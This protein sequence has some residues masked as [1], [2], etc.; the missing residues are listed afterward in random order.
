MRK[1][2]QIMKVVCYK[3][4]T[5][6]NGEHPL[7]MRV[8]KNGKAVYR[9]IGISVNA[10]HWDFEKEQPK[11]NCPNKAFILKLILDKEREYNDK[12]IEL[13]S[14]QKDF[15]AKSLFDKVEKKITPMTVSEMF[16]WH[17]KNLN[18]DGRLKYALEFEQL[19]N[20]MLKFKKH[21]DIYFSEID[22]RWLENY[23]R[24]MRREGGLKTNTIGKRMRT[25]RRLYN[26]AIDEH[27]VKRDY[28]PFESYHV[29]KLTEKTDNRALAKEDIIGKIINYEPVTPE[30]YHFTRKRKDLTPYEY[31]LLSKDIFLF[32]YYAAGINFTDIAYLTRNNIIGAKLI[33]NKYFNISNETAKVF[34]KYVRSKTKKPIKVWLLKKVLK[35]IDKYYGEN[36][37]MEDVMNKL[38]DEDD[39]AW[40]DATFE[41]VAQL[42]EDD[43]HGDDS[44]HK[45]D[46]V[47]KED[48]V[49]VDDD[50]ARLYVEDDT[51]RLYFDDDDSTEDDTVKQLF[52]DDII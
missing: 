36:K 51:V 11:F 20:S 16:D 2:E 21:L 3:S 48:R 43:S 5:L 25:L 19:Q 38:V 41:D 1:T 27:A 12:V 23:E 14:E 45:D 6:A 34:L 44:P 49:Y 47:R 10:K 18:N 30:N 13:A 50:T 8:I 32:S 33:D 29:G 31:M 52:G 26:L 35:I 24:W 39:T 22:K 42:F 17:I 7:M 37:Q 15:T 46:A 28:Y 40:D 4:K 9:S